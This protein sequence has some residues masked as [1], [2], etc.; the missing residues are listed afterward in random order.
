M[1][2]PTVLDPN[3]TG[4]PRAGDPISDEVYWGLSWRA[5]ETSTGTR[6]YHGGSNSTGFRCLTEFNPSTGNGIIM[7]T[8]GF[9]G[10]TLRD[11]E[12][13]IISKP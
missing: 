8:Y 12:F 4:L 9:G 6:C 11:K 5:Q 13:A 2:H 3:R 7:M 10:S 1:L